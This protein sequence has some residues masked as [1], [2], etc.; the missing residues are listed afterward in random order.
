LQ[1]LRREHVRRYWLLIVDATMHVVKSAV[2]ERPSSFD[3]IGF[4]HILEFTC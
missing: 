4:T 3:D 2:L 1:W